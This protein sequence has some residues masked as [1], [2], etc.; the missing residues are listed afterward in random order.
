MVSRKLW[1]YKQGGQDT[2][3]KEKL[4]EVCAELVTDAVSLVRGRP[5]SS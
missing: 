2:G 5:E 1:N 4:I 3:P